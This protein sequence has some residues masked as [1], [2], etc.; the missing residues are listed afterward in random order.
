MSKKMS[1]NLFLLKNMRPKTGSK[2]RNDADKIITMY[3]NGDIANVKTAFNL[4]IYL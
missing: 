4:N 3:E 1:N 2:Y